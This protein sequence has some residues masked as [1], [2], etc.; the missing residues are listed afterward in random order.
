MKYSEILLR[1]MTI[2]Y[3]FLLPACIF[4]ILLLISQ[5]LERSLFLGSLLWDWMARIWIALGLSYVY[6]NLSDLDKYVYRMYRMK[7][8]SSDSLPVNWQNVILGI[9]FGIMSIPFT[10]WVILMFLPIFVDSALF[11]S[12]LHGLILSIPIVVFQKKFMP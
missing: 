9:I 6:I 12:V 8:E 7:A 10:W 5:Q 11:L 3:R 2:S 1:I 4:T